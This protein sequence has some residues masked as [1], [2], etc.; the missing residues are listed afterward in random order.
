MERSWDLENINRRNGHRSDREG[1]I[2]KDSENTHLVNELDIPITVLGVPDAVVT[3]SPDGILVTDKEASPRIKS[4]MKGFEQRP[5]YEERRWSWYK[6]LDYT[7]YEE[8]HEVLTK[9][10]GLNAGKNLSYQLHHKRSEVWTIVKGAGEFV[11][12]DEIRRVKAGDVVHIPVGSKHG[13]KAVTDMEF[14]E[15]K[16]GSVLV[17]EDVE[18]IY[19]DW[20]DVV[21]NCVYM[22]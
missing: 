11:L 21:G 6:V 20:E 16:T 4:V 13:M 3:A 7:K 22:G 9:R 10:L 8:G 1:N 19:L 12:D 2:S 17:E 5:M 14:I 18:L 15:V